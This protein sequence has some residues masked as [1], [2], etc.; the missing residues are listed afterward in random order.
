[1]APAASTFSC[2]LLA[3]RPGRAKT[4][5]DSMRMIPKAPLQVSIRPATNTLR[6]LANKQATGCASGAHF[7]SL[8]R[9]RE[10]KGSR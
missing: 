4:I 10:K 1:M 3:P 2:P 7:S 6:A 9:P 8:V 5:D